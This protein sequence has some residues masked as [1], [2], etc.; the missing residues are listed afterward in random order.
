MNPRKERHGLP[1]LAR[2]LCMLISVTLGLAPAATLAQEPSRAPE[3]TPIQEPASP[4]PPAA[5]PFPLSL[6]GSDPFSLGLYSFDPAPLMEDLCRM[7]LAAA[8]CKPESNY[9]FVS[10]RQPDQNKGKRHAQ[11]DPQERILIFSGFYGAKDVQFYCQTDDRRIILSSEAWG[12]KRITAPYTVD[13]EKRCLT[14]DV[15]A[16]A[17]GGRK[18]IRACE[19][20]R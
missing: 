18:G 12:A 2:A 3:P 5:E 20:S 8:T 14:A 11:N 10:E 6:Q 9:N 17:C 1:G 13:Q 19:E 16:E 15:H 7:A 4:P